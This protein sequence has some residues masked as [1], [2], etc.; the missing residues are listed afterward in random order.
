MGV[1]KVTLPFGTGTLLERIHAVC[2]QTCGDVVIAVGEYGA[3]TRAFPAAFR[4]IQ[5]PGRGPLPAIAEALHRAPTGTFLFVTACDTP[6]LQ[7]AVVES[8]FGHAANHRGA[9]PLI[10]GRSQP[11]CAVY[12]AALANEVADLVGK[13]ERRANALAHLPGVVSVPEDSLRNADPDLR[14]FRGCN[15]IE[16]Y[17]ALLELAGEPVPHEF[18]RTAGVRVPPES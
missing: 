9:V 10:Q 2:Q 8:L 6:L 15:T 14:S 17:L 13:G 18:L 5:D 1:D 16:E 12:A 7:P 4:T 11:T 3:E